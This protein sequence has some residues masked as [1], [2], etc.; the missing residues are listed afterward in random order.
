MIPDR[1]ELIARLVNAARER[2]ETER[3]A[4]LIAACGGDTTLRREIEARLAHDRSGGS[5]TA[6]IPANNAANKAIDTILTA[7]APADRTGFQPGAVV[8]RR[9]RIV[10]LLGRGGMAEVYRADDLKVGQRVALKFL[11]AEFA[12]DAGRMRRLVTE[13]RLARQISH[14]NVCR[15]YDI[16]EADGRHYLSMEYID[17]EDLASLLQRI[18]RLPHEK[19]LEIARQL[20]AGLAAAHDQGV[21]HR[22][23]KPAN[24]MID[25]RGRARI[26]DFGL[27]VTTE[28][29][30][31]GEIAG[32]PAY[33]AP[34]QAASGSLTAQTDIFALG[35]VL[36][37]LLTGTRLFRVATPQQ[38]RQSERDAEAL[39]R[40]ADIDP[41]IKSVIARCLKTDPAA[42]PAS[43]R[44]VASGLP[45][46]SDPMLA[47]LAAGEIPSPEMVAAAGETGRL[48]PIAAGVC[49][50]L[51]IVGLLTAAWQLRPMM[52]Y[53][54]IT[55]TKPPEALAE[56]ARQVVTRLGYTEDPV[57]SAYWFVTPQPYEEMARK[58]SALYDAPSR[59]PRRSGLFFV[60]RQSP[61]LL[62]PENTFGVIQYREPPADVPG[63]ADVTLDPA[64]RLLRFTAVP[65]PRERATPRAVDWAS[66][67]SEAGL[68]DRAFAS[69]E[70]QW[71]PPIAH[72]LVAAWEGAA[73]NRPDERISIIA[74]AWDGRPVVFDA[75]RSVPSAAS[76]TSV[77]S[78]EPLSQPAFF[79][80]TLAALAG[81]GI[82]ARW[83]MR[84]G[85]WDRSGALKLAA[86]V[87]GIGLLLGLLRADHVARARDEY[88]I[89]V[90]IASW[91]LFY[92]GFTFLI[93]V[94]FEPFVRERWPRVLISWNRLLSG[95]L[96][97]PL[98]GEEIL[99]G[100]LAGVAVVLLREAEF[101][102][103]PWL[104]LAVPDPF[105]SP[106]DA[107]GSWRQCA[108]LALF[109]P[110][111]AL[112]LA[113]AWLLILL[114]LRIALRHDWLAIVATV[115]VSLPVVTLPGD[116]LLLETAVGLVITAVSVFVLLQFG[117][118]AA[119][120]EVS[121]GSALMRLPITLDFSEWYAG[122]T[123]VVLLGLMSL[124][125]YGFHTSLGG[126]RLFARRLV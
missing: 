108:S 88:L 50:G 62:V 24:I 119:V 26:A 38:R 82:L 120:I 68:D 15:V 79:I 60:Y 41:S 57:A 25:G 109:I 14:P 9:Y 115:L 44:A 118:V 47:A 40:S 7:T 17:G 48:R 6:P 73:A 111:E 113:L 107:L 121:V 81:A 66:A 28:S 49:L 126:R 71:R 86:Y 19:V 32:T 13:V 76:D 69:R 63:M 53:R 100:S 30:T 112:G 18:G 93:Y 31:A 117:L 124:V 110:L 104:G 75:T 5:V 74:A 85:R 96:R 114:L 58:R 11:A 87:F 52:L 89:F 80:M 42:R 45:G 72:D 77:R 65:G 22:D 106:M 116:H 122:R 90:R 101:I 3:P 70:T 33:M 20:C 10:S 8:G 43:V 64:G 61:R 1:A 92:A 84:Q 2:D 4:F 35:L 51:A 39:V 67:F 59:V 98:V 97:D 12:D 16:G 99:I 78:E 56:R 46:G 29:R 55:M 102:V 103:P 54:Q 27:A 123:V 91:N 125:V 36:Y 105:A 21:L 34:E 94:A 83:N 37:E 95:R 23:L